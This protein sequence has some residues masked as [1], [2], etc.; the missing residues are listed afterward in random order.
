VGT[1]WD[2]ILQPDLGDVLVPQPMNELLRS[3]YFAQS[4]SISPSYQTA[5]GQHQ[6]GTDIMD[7]FGSDLMPYHS[8]DDTL[9]RAK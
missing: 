9:H 4:L 1:N 7:S 8:T 5:Y 3:G 2:T 6:F